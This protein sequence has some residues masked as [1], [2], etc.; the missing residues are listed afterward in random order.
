AAVA[1]AWETDGAAVRDAAGRIADRLSG[2]ARSLPAA[3]VDEATLAGAV[4]ALE[5]EFDR[6]AAGFG[7]A[8]KFPPSAVLEFLLRHHERTGSEPALQLAEGTC[9]AMARGGMYD[10]L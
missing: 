10:Q 9:E 2:V 4:D 8:P 5:G 7:G 6:V 3:A 1:K